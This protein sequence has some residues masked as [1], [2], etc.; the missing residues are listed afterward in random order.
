MHQIRRTLWKER[1][2]R[3][4]YFFVALLFHILIFMMVATVIVF[5]APAPETI[6]EFQAIRIAVPPPPPT[7]PPSSGET[8][9]TPMEPQPV[10]VPPSAPQHLINSAAGKT[11]QV[12]TSLLTSQA[13][14]HI[15]LPPP[16]STGMAQ[17]AGSE[18]SNSGR[19]GGVDFFGVHAEGNHFAFLLDHSGSMEGAFRKTME[20]QLE[21]ALKKL[22]DG[23]QVIVI[24]WA[25][26]AWL[27]N[28]T[29]AQIAKKWH[30]LGSYD[31][32]EL[33]PGETLDLPRW[34]EINATAIDDIMKG[35]KSQ[36][37]A[38]GGT[39]WRQPF[40]YAMKSTPPPDAI[41]FLTDGQIPGASVER[42]L[43]VIDTALKK[44]PNLPKVNCLWIENKSTK[45]TAMEKLAKKYH[46]E[47][48]TVTAKMPAR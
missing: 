4:G 20:S 9:N 34:I 5:K 31:N 24:C 14:S 41:F 30:R 43:T 37:P 13:L 29:H 3:S 40:I 44:A 35:I 47:F 18:G 12:D 36:T 2:S 17:G 16:Q 6:A 15:S 28:Q 1:L 26:A 39:D 46:G 38:P 45:G 11:F 42:T 21:S 27:H 25:G 33:N 7:P 19:S 10:S 48:R 8:V 23:A 32:F 22:P